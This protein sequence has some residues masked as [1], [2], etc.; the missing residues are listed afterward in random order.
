MVQRLLPKAF[1]LFVGFAVLVG[2]RFDAV[3]QGLA[4]TSVAE[5][6]MGLGQ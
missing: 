1:S 6:A 5:K 2:G 4:L 3:K